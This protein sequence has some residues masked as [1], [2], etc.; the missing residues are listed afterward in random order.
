[1][2]EMSV[3]LT[4][5]LPRSRPVSGDAG[6]ALGDAGAALGDAGATP[7]SGA[8]VA[9]TL[10]GGVAPASALRLIE[11]GEAGAARTLA[12][13]LSASAP[14]TTSLSPAASPERTSIQPSLVFIPSVSTRSWA[15]S[16][17]TT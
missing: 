2:I 13:S 8:L 7:S 9:P 17:S 14:R 12:P 10:G 1:L 4:A 16:P 5:K 11:A 6:A 15:T 3:M